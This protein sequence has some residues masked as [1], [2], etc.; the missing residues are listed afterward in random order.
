MT[1]RYHSVFHCEI[2]PPGAPSG[3]LLLL[4]LLLLLAG[5]LQKDR[6]RLLQTPETELGD[7]GQFGSLRQVEDPPADSQALLLQG[8]GGEVSSVAVH[9]T[10]R[11]AAGLQ[12][13]AEVRPVSS[14]HQPPLTSLLLRHC[15]HNNINVRFST[16]IFNVFLFLKVCFESLFDTQLLI[17]GRRR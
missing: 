7:V 13:C 12:D 5:V 1:S 6:D 10:E 2:S 8:C 17:I 9:R 14:H 3:A 11:A 16:L 15:G 4:L